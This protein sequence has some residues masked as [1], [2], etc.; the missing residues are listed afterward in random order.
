MHTFCNK[1]DVK[2]LLE[3]LHEHTR[4]LLNLHAILGL[5]LAHGEKSFLYSINFLIL[6]VQ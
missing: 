5:R 1:I 6:Y 4:L 3:R 2:L